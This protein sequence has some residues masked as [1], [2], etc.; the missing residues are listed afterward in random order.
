MG[1]VSVKVLVGDPTKASDLNNVREDV[2]AAGYYSVAQVDNDD[3][4]PVEGVIVG[5]SEAVQFSSLGTS[6]C[7]F[8]VGLP[9]IIDG[10]EDWEIRIGFDMDATDAGK[11][12]QLELE[13][14]V[15]A[16]GG[17]TSPTTTTVSETVTT[18]DTSDTYETVVLSTIK[19]PSASM[20]TGNQISFKLSRLAG[21]VNDTHG[22]KLRIFNIELFQNQ[23]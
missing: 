4:N 1:A 12:I 5:N 21:H 6:T 17:D 16:D 18:P 19:I 14:G 11:A 8:D 23:T 9:K 7:Y 2:L 10:S 13:Y 20:I 3:T 22:G 15:T